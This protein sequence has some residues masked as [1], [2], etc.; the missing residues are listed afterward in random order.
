MH[1]AMPGSDE[2]VDRKLAFHPTKERGERFLMARNFRHVLVGQRRSI[3]VLCNEMPA[4][5]NVFEFAVADQT[6]R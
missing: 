1:H 3:A 6:Q 4:M 2:A 5:S